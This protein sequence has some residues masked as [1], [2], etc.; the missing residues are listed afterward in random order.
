MGTPSFPSRPRAPLLLAAVLALSACATTPSGPSMLV[1]PGGSKPFD[2]FRGDD[3]SCRNY[4]LA[5][6]GGNE[7]DRAAADSMARSMAL[8]TAVG[9]VAG[10]AIGGRQGAGVGAGTGLLVGSAAGAGAGQSSAYGVQQRYDHAYIQ[11]MYAAGH[12]VPVRGEFTDLPTKGGAA[13]PPPPPR[14]ATR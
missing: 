6:V 4:A 3:A 12:R 2:V 7:A 11:C 14:K 13:L 5:A 10:A 8:G 1:L 9:A